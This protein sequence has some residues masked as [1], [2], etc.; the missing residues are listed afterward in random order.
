[1]PTLDISRFDGGLDLRKG[2]A[3]NDANR[4]VQ[5]ENAFVTNGLALQK[6]PGL[7]KSTVLPRGTSGLFYL[8]GAPCVFHVVSPISLPS[9]FRGYKLTPKVAGAPT[10]DIRNVMYVDAFNGFIYG[11]FQMSDNTTEHHYFD[12]SASTYV[13]DANCPHSAIVMKAGSKLFSPGVGG[14]TLRFS[15]TGNARDWTEANNAGF[16]ATGLHAR[17]AREINA[18]GLYK[19]SLVVLSRDNA[20]IWEIDPDPV[21]MR[22]SSV[23][24]NVG[25]KYNNTVQGMA[26]D[27]YFLNDYGFRGL[28]TLMYTNNLADS[29]I[30]SPIDKIVRAEVLKGMPDQQP[31][32]MYFY[33]TGQYM[34]WINRQML[35]YSYSRAS[36]IAAWS[37]YTFPAI[38]GRLS[39]MAEGGGDA[40]FRSDDTI[41]KLDAT[42]YTDDGKVFNVVIQLPYLDLK[43]PGRLKHVYGIDLVMEG[44]ATVSVGWDSRDETAFTHPVEVSGNTRAGEIIPVGCTGTEFS[45]KVVNSDDKPF[46]LDSIT[47]HFD[48]LGVF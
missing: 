1:M 9:P 6:R 42:T 19:N 38:G 40:F 18:L 39:A 48:D 31:F 3:V 5:L 21:K 37:R 17:G 33:G 27:L 26:G 14:Q 2:I 8:D 29:D 11:A 15:R 4:Q 41:Y 35:V 24:E 20:Q 44:N 34:T 45:I 12:N 28:T 7:R 23:V 46:R 43:K 25:S 30:G 22:L 13:A 10:L 47:V 36:K 16:L 32:S